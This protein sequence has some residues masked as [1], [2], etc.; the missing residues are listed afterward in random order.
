MESGEILEAGKHSQ[1]L[2]SNGRYAA[3]W[4]RQ[5]DVGA[6]KDSDSGVIP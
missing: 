6:E 3:L 2:R 4:Q 5:A 1:L